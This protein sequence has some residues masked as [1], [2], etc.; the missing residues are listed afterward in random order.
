[1]FFQTLMDHGTRVSKEL[2]KSYSIRA[3]ADT[4]SLAQKIVIIDLGIS[5]G[6]FGFKNYTNILSELSTRLVVYSVMSL[7]SYSPC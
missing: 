3:S 5:L 1:M 2:A 4:M 7:L 6:E